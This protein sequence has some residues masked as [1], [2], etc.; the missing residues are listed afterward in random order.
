[1]PGICIF[2]PLICAY[3]FWGYSRVC[4][5]S[6]RLSGGLPNAKNA[7]K[8]KLA[9]LKIV[10]MV[11]TSLFSGF[12]VVFSASYGIKLCDGIALALDLLQTKKVAHSIKLGAGLFRSIN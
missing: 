2:V 8:G 7:S 11:F 3:T 5:Q 6:G 4:R 10:A 9:K 12:I 1:M